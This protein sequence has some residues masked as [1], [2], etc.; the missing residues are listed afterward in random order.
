MFKHRLWHFNL[1]LVFTIRRKLLL[2]SMYFNGSTKFKS[3]RNMS[4]PNL[5]FSELIQVIICEF[6]RKSQKQEKVWSDNENW[7]SNA[8]SLLFPVLLPTQ[9]SHNCSIIHIG[10]SRRSACKGYPSYQ[11]L[12]KYLV[13]VAVVDKGMTFH[14]FLLPF[15]SLGVESS[16]GSFFDILKYQKNFTLLN[17]GMVAAC[18]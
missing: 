14:V 11:Q 18:L 6:S 8:L 2:R 3:F 4:S 13:L 5:T 12:P 1:K 7:N 16:R 15:C 10:S 9:Y 17:G